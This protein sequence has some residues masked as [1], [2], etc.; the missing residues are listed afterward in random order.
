MKK[1][2][3]EIIEKIPESGRRDFL[4]DSLAIL[5]AGFAAPPF[6]LRAFSAKD[7]KKTVKGEKKTIKTNFN[8]RRIKTVIGPPYDKY[9]GEKLKYSVDFLSTFKAAEVSVVFRPGYGGKLIA[10]IDAV[11]KGVVGW[12][13]NMKRQFF[14][15]YLEI[16]EVGGK[17]RLV[18]TY[19][20]RISVKGEKTYKSVHRFDY[21][22]G[23]WHFRKYK[24]GRRKERWS[25]P[26]PSGVFYEDF[27]GFMYNVRAGF[28]GEMKP[29]HEFSIRSVPFKEID[30]YTVHVAS[31][32]QMDAE[33]KWIKKTPGAA[34]M[35]I[36][37]IHQKIFGMKTGE[38]KVLVD[39]DL[40]PL[41]G[42]V[43]DAVSFGDVT[44]NLVERSKA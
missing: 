28:Y 38:G 32:Q 35:G 2:E 4:E 43:K 29:G 5:L 37:D 42:K 17:Q 18:V 31:G 15:S 21:K 33:R 22:R 26:I 19:F 14:R 24:N 27:A 11:A 12:A 30:S 13:T 34:L 6:L 7:D 16:M 10:E 20:S 36:V 8:S 39:K 40:L 44:V 9:L 25:K 1:D 23:K 41:S 3:I